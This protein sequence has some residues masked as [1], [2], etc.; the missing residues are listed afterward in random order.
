MV[1][2]K[3]KTESLAGSLWVG[4]TVQLQVRPVP[5]PSS[6]RTFEVAHLMHEMPT[7]LE[8]R[9]NARP[10]CRRIFDPNTQD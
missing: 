2:V 6:Q 5:T 9:F 7:E 3:C 10:R 1:A 4:S 8:R